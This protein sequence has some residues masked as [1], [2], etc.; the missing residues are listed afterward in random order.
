MARIIGLTF[1]DAV[2]SAPEKP[3]TKKEIIAVLEAAGIEYPS[4]A[5]VAELKAL[6]PEE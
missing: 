1:A 2:K 4:E 6:L 3:K 5:T